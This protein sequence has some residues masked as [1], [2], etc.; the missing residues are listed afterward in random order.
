ME[1]NVVPSEKMSERSSTASP[2]RRHELRRADDGRLRRLLHEELPG[3]LEQP[4]VAN[5]QMPLA[6]QQE[7]VRLQVAVNDRMPVSVV[8]PFQRLP[9]PAQGQLGGCDAVLLEPVPQ[10][11]AGHVFHGHPAQ[12][13]A[14]LLGGGAGGENRHD[15][16]AAKLGQDECFLVD[17]LQELVILGSF[18]MK[19]LD[20]HGPIEA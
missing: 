8:Q 7:I 13:A 4:E 6:G 5:F 19:D 3:P 20:G 11:A 1:K 10:V 14:G 16:G 18:V 17:P 15:L 12:G 9:E 2:N